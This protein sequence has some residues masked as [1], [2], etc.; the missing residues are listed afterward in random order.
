MNAGLGAGVASRITF[1]FESRGSSVVD[2]RAHCFVRA[3]GLDD[4]AAHLVVD[5]LGELF[6]RLVPIDA[7]PLANGHR[8]PLGTKRLA[9]KVGVAQAVDLLDMRLIREEVGPDSCP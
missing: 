1:P 9:V 8:H 5:V 4:V 7:Q 6:A 2:L 3:I